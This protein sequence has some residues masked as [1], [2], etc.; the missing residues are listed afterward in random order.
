MFRGR[1]WLQPPG[2]EAGLLEGLLGCGG[3]RSQPKAVR[4]LR[5]ITPLQAP[6]PLL[7]DW[8]AGARSVQRQGGG[9]VDVQRARVL[10]G[11]VSHCGWGK[12]LHSTP[13][14]AA[15]LPQSAPTAPVAGLGLSHSLNTVSH[16][17]PPW[18]AQI[19]PGVL[20]EPCSLS[21]V[22]LYGRGGG[23]RQKGEKRAPLFFSQAGMSGHKLTA[24]V[25]GRTPLPHIPETDG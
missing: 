8:H 11:R 3:V 20:R 9:Q 17:C 7:T 19:C 25:R 18:Q 2:E 5:A 15:P 23:P 10:Q 12:T 24:S 13:T 14:G 22:F 1:R 21:L 16:C 6:S 4:H